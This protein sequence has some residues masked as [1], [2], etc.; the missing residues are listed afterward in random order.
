MMGP[1]CS[2]VPFPHGNGD[3]PWGLFRTA[4]KV[5]RLAF[6]TLMS[7]PFDAR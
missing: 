1:Q 4:P 7:S 2:N 6:L 5:F 3:A